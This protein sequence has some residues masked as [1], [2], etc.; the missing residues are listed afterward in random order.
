MNRQQRRAAAKQKSSG[1]RD[2]TSKARA[3]TG[4]TDLLKA[5]LHHHQTGRLPE[6]EALYRQV[7]TIKPDNADVLFNLGVALKQQGKADE[8]I[9]AYRQTIDIRPNYAEAHYNL[10]NLLLG[11]S[12][13]DEAID[14]Y[15]HAIQ[16]NPDHAD[17]NSNL[18]VALKR[19]GKLD[20]AIAALQRT[21]AINAQHAEAYC[22]LGDAQMALRKLDEAVD[23]YRHAIRVRPDY[24]VAYFNLGVALTGQ[25]KSDEA[26]AAYRQ[27]IGINSDLVEAHVNLGNL[28]SGLGK[29]DEA[30]AAYRRASEIEPD[31]VAA[32]YNLGNAL[33]DQGR[34][35]D[36]ATAYRRAISIN[37]NHAEA[38]ANLAI[39]LMW[40]GK[41]DAALTEYRQAIAIEPD[42]AEIYSNY[43]LCLNY[44]DTETP[45]SL[46]AAHRDWEKRY[47]RSS[48]QPQAYSNNRTIGRR[49]KIGYVSPDLRSHSV[50]YFFEPLLRRHDRQAVEV[51]CYAEVIRPDA[52]TARLQRLADHWLSIVGL[53]DDEL[54]K[55]IKADGI[56][57]LVD[58]AG[59][60]AWN[61][62]AVFARK[63]APLQVTWLGYANTTGL[64][65]MDYRLV[66]AVTD[67]VG[68]ADA[69]ASETLLRLTDGFL[70]YGGSEGSPEPAD[71]PCLTTGIITFGSFNNPAKVSP[72]TFGAWAKLLLRLPQARLLLKGKPFA[73]AATCALSLAQFAERGVSA[74]RIEL[75][76]WFPSGVDHL[77]LYDRV[78]VALDPFPYN[79]TTTT[80]EALWMGVPLVTFMG[81]RHSGRVGASLLSQIGLNNWIAH[82]IDEYVEIAVALA[83]NR[84]RLHELRRS[85]RLR[86]AASSLCDEQSFARRMEDSFRIIWQRWCEAPD[87]NSRQ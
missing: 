38:H 31:S 76:S 16:I 54:T 85:L 81:D 4:A 39:V 80:C 51:F 60:T 62:L 64:T 28:L 24:A 40:Q 42:S 77:A 50:A 41:H 45:E 17:A 53:S 63:P 37:S 35:D 2:D 26:I 55:R 87:H 34:L 44:S 78:D 20:E 66:D 22:N 3:T 79:G 13:L 14:S 84:T 47:V 73:D 12:K 36:A 67:P 8:A 23:A 57:I 25:D 15:R 30:A 61:R 46:F 59:H 75:L 71:P 29:L 86:M 19:Q 58:L 6:A 56:D 69:C 48:P 18:G 27:A 32:H 43:L 82:S 65:A 9:A 7:L 33:K 68:R 70:C 10:G 11:L 83:E 5:A 72:A 52:V 21:T 1:I 74:E 49:L